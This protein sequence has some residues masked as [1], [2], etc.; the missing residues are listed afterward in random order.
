MD[1]YIIYVGIGLIVFGVLKFLRELL[2]Y[3]NKDIV[4]GEVIAVKEKNKNG[5]A[6]SYPKVKVIEGNTYNEFYCY[7]AKVN[8][9]DT[10]DVG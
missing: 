5:R 9:H 7:S 1:D 4:E 10:Y 2:I 6:Y 3:K 8:R